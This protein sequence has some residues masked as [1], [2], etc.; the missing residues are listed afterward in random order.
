MALN[1]QGPHSCAKAKRLRQRRLDNFAESWSK[2]I[3]D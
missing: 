2:E 1:H 3:T